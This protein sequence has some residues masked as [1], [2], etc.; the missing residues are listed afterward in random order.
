MN[1]LYA[2]MLAVLL[3]AGILSG[4]GTQKEEQAN[5]VQEEEKQEVSVQIEISKNNGEE[6]LADK[7]LSVEEGATLMKVLEDNF[8]V[9]QSDGMINSIEGIS[10]NQD[11]KMAWMYTINGEEAQVG[12]NDYEL[13][14][15]DEIVFDYHSWE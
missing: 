2:L 7:E 6:I 13:K 15:G 8:E 1:K 12:A 10:A 11:K 5:A 14:Q 9:E 3:T 4:C